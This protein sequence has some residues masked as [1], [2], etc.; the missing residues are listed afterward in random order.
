MVRQDVSGA[1]VPNTEVALRNA[2]ANVER[3]AQTNDVGLYV[4]LDILP[5]NHTREATKQGFKTSKA[6]DFT[7]AVNQT[8]TQDFALEV[9][10]QTRR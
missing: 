6:A 9:G 7:L 8:L 3:Q 4:F 5:R 2:N 10:D 1:V